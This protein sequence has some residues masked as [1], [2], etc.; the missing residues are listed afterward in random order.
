MGVKKL[1][2]FVIRELAFAAVAVT[3]CALARWRRYGRQRAR[4]YARTCACQ[5]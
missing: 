4:A 2:H 3:S 5:L 1:K